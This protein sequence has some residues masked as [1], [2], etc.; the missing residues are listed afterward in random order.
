VKGH[1]G[2]LVQAISAVDKVIGEVNTQA[3]QVEKEIHSACEKLRELMNERETQLL[4]E[5]E[6]VRHEKEKELVGQKN[7]LEFLLVGIREST[8][9]G[10]VLVKQG[11]KGEIVASQKNVVSR[12]TTLGQ[13]KEKSQME[14][15]TDFVI[16]FE[17]DTG[18]LRQVGEVIK[19]LGSIVSKDI[20]TEKSSVE[21]QPSG[22][23][24]ITQVVSFK[25]LVVDKKG[26]RVTSSP[27]G[28]GIIPFVVEITLNGNQQQQQVKIEENQGKEGEFSV[29]FTPTTAGPHQISVS[30]KGEHV[31][32]SPFTIEVVN[33]PICRRDYNTVGTNPVLQ[34]G[35]NGSGDGQFRNLS[36][37]LCNSKGD[38]VVVEHGNHRVQVFDKA[39]KFLFKFGSNGSGLGQLS[40][41]WGVTV[42]HRNNQIV[43]ADTSNHRIQV[44]EGFY[45][46]FGSSGSGDGQLS[47]P[48]DV[49]VDSQGNYFVAEDSNHRVSVFDSNGQFLR[50]FGSNGNGNG[51]L[52]NP[53]GVGLLS[54][55]NVVVGEYSNAR[56]SIFDSQGN[57]IRHVGDGQLSNPYHHFVD[58]DDNILVADYSGNCIQVFK[59]DGSLV[60]TIGSGQLSSPSG[61]CMDSEGRIIVSEYGSHRISIF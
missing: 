45:R 53:R 32:G 51:Q 50:K 42:D 6:T 7:H 19:G 20:S 40:S 33:R 47:N 44:F 58:S 10:E 5:V 29:S 49:V 17:G 13:E 4:R 31:K 28:Q 18:G 12:L 3:E 55:G 9:F 15:V 25:V 11:S 43:V 56:V 22:S 36:N 52:S 54:N 27:K 2:S 30:H 16:V 61:V 21:G 8:Q 41:P 23:V 34:F 1:D 24:V 38:I 37:V 59:A 26:N 39:G 14:P 57:F 46:A 35:S 48:H 60:K